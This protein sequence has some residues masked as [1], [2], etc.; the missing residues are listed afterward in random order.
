MPKLLVKLKQ[1]TPL[2]HF[3]A[4]QDGATL[5]ATEVKSR[6]DNFIV[7]KK[8]GLKKVNEKLYEKYKNVIND[9]NFPI[10]EGDKI[11]S[12]YKLKITSANKIYNLPDNTAY[13]GKKNVLWLDN[14]K[15]EVFSFNKEI[16]NLIKEVMPYIF[17]YNNFGL[18]QSKGFGGFSVDEWKLNEKKW[19]K[20]KEQFSPKDVL[21]KKYNYFFVKEFNKSK[22]FLKEI[23]ITYQKLKS[24]NNSNGKLFDYMNDKNNIIWEKEKIKKELKKNYTEW[25]NKLKGDN[26]NI[27]KKNKKYKYIRA[28]LGLAEHNEYLLKSKGKLVV[29]ITDKQGKIER[30]RSPITFKVFKNNIYVLVNDI[31]D[32]MFDRT[33]QFRLFYKYKKEDG[34]DE[35]KTKINKSNNVFLEMKTPTKEEFNIEE[36]LSEYLPE[37][38]KK[39]GEQN[40]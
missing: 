24:G 5:R 2:I 27:S 10:N 26:S 38:Y 8:N 3:Q 40:A 21:V 12:P 32:E 23:N 14:I 4:D 17:A 7:D 37:G 35:F 6:L 9:N 25:F 1:H 31:S 13:F 20:Y 36:F 22:D 30:F 34:K 33:F 19:D 16:I 39:V 29:D 15:I 18:R 28:L 11:P